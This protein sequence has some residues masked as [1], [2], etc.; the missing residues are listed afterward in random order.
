LGGVEEWSRWRRG[1][2]FFG[3]GLKTPS[4]HFDTPSL[5]KNVWA[6][7]YFF[8]VREK[9]LDY[10]ENGL[11]ARLDNIPYYLFKLEGVFVNTPKKYS[12][13]L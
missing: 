11:R 1:P 12:S 6:K 5:Q 9:L 13:L 3:E 4:F 2:T 7:P 10:F 8:V